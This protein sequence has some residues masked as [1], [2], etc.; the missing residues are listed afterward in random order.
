[1]HREI[2]VAEKWLEF[3]SKLKNVVKGSQ[4]HHAYKY[5]FYVGY[6]GAILNMKRLKEEFHPIMFDAIV[7][8]NLLEI[9]EYLEGLKNESKLQE[10]AI[11]S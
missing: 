10:L 3:E 7:D 11:A 6:L 5:V 9:E 1:M 8:G 4:Q 2:T